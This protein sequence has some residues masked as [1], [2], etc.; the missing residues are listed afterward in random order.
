VNI[1][2]ENRF[3]IWIYGFTAFTMLVA[4]SVFGWLAWTSRAEPGIGRVAGTRPSNSAT[5]P[6]PD[7]Q[8]DLL[9]AFEAPAYKPQRGAPKT[10]PAAMTLYSKRDYA[11]AAFALRA[12]MDAQPQFVPAKFYLGISLLLTGDRIAGIQELR[13]VTMAGNGPYLERA[14]FYLAKGLIGE[15]DLTRAQQQLEDVIAQHGALE[16]QATVL[17]G[18]IRAS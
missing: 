15:H 11:G 6:I 13:D 4:M 16:K 17:L 3:W 8:Y 10:F 7:E 5:S 12:V 18:R 2:P 14:R 1:K 9:A